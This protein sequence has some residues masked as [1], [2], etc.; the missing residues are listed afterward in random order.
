MTPHQALARIRAAGVTAPVDLAMVLGTGLGGLADAVEDAILIP[1][2][3]LPGFPA[4]GVSGHAG[5]LVIGQLEGLRV[6]FAQGRAHYYEHGDARAMAVPID[7][8]AA[9]GA[10]VLLLSN[11]CGSLRADWRPGSL[12]L[13]NDHINYA[14]ANPLIGVA[15]DS[16]FVSMTNAYDAELLRTMRGAAEAA[17]LSPHEGVYMWYSG[18]SFETPAEIRMA[19]I[20]GAD[21]IGMSTVPE[22]ILARHLGLK[23]AAISIITNLAAG[24]E[25]ASPSHSETKEV[26]NLGAADFQRLIRAFLRSYGQS[27]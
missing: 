16:R 18:P 24:I 2:S 20:L 8:F 17:Q 13:L 27:V 15:S 10:K 23:V 22:V 9:L 25:G 5:R 19:R 21:V 4:S 1:Y 12:V 14:G 3:E 6:A 26:A 7:T 11:A